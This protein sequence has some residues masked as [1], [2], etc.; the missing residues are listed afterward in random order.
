[1]GIWLAHTVVLPN[2]VGMRALIN[3]VEIVTGCQGTWRQMTTA[4]GGHK[5]Y[6]PAGFKFG[7][8]EE[9]RFVNTE[10][11][12]SDKNSTVQLE[13]TAEKV[14]VTRERSS[15]GARRRGPR[16]CPS[17]GRRRPRLWVVGHAHPQ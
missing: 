9:S 11:H 5:V 16:A 12:K 1:M 3:G 10:V 13:E 7:H 14:F 17:A 4:N 15:T 2:A 8:C 6:L